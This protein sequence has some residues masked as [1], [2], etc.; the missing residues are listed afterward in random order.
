MTAISDSAGNLTDKSTTSFTAGIA[1]VVSHPS[2]HVLYVVANNG[3]VY[4]FSASTTNGAL[5]SLA[6]KIPDATLTSPSFAAVAPNGKFLYVVDNVASTNGLV[7]VYTISSTTGA[8]TQG[9]T[10]AGT[11]GG[12]T[13]NAPY[14]IAITPDNTRAYV[15]YFGSSSVCAFSIN[16]T[17]GA[18]T[19]I[20]TTCISATNSVFALAVS[21]A[22]NE[23]YACGAGAGIDKYAINSSTGALTSGG[24]TTLPG[25]SVSVACRAMIRAGDYLIAAANNGSVSSFL[26]NASGTLGTPASLTLSGFTNSSNSIDGMAVTPANDFVLFSDG[27]E[28]KIFSAKLSATGTLT[29]SSA[30]FTTK[31]TTPIPMAFLNL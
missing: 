8:L 16:A 3:D 18:L 23:L 12:N 1:A 2:L 20:G 15:G 14:S 10:F 30:N 6:T 22:S 9:S 4:Q 25:T 21:K 5:T 17:T 11:D 29:Q 19:E 24:L 7:R 31:M 13:P 27:N 26:I 28:N